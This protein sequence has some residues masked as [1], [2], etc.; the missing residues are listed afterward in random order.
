MGGSL[1]LIARSPDRPP[2]ELSGIAEREPRDWRSRRIVHSL[3]A[4]THIRP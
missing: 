1:S 3:Y 2:V 4:T